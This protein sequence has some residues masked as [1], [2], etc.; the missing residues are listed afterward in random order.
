MTQFGSAELV[1]DY[2]DFG[3]PQ[4]LREALLQS[5]PGGPRLFLSPDGRYLLVWLGPPRRLLSFLHLPASPPPPQP[6][7]YLEHSWPA[8][9][10]P[11]VGLLFPQSPGQAWTMALVWE[12][13]RAEVWAPPRGP[14]DPS[15]T[16]LRSVELCQGPRARVV[17]ACCCHGDEL[18]WCEERTTANLL[19]Y[20][21]CRRSLRVSGRR[22][23]PGA[24]TIV[25]HHSPPYHVLESAGRVFMVPRATTASGCHPVLVYA[26]AEALVTLTGLAAGV[27]HSKALGEADAD[28]KKLILECAG[29]AAD[30]EI[31]H[32]AAAGPRGLL[33]ATAAGRIHLLH[34]D[35]TARHVYDL[36]ENLGASAQIKMA[37]SGDTLVCAVDSCLYLVDVRSGRLAVKQ[38]LDAGE[39]LLIDAPEGG[40]DVWLMTKV[41]VYKVGRGGVKSGMAESALLDM[42]YEEAC[43]YYQ[44]RSL[45]SAKLTAQSLKEN[46]MFQ[47]PIALAAILCRKSDVGKYAELLG[48]I[49]NELQSFLSL[50]RLKSRAAGAP[51]P[52]VARC[53]DE[54]VDLELTRLLQADPDRDGLAY[55]NSL[56]HIFPKAAWASVRNNFQFQQNGDGKLV[57]RATADLWKKVLSPLPPSAS[58]NGLLPL[59]EVICQSL[60]T[61]KPKWLPGFVQHAQEC[62]GL[63]RNFTTTTKEH[64]E[65]APPLY[66]RALSVLNKRKDNTNVELEVE[67]LLCSGRPQ[68]IIQAIHTLIRLQRWPRVMGETRRYSQLNPLIKKDIFITLLVEFVQHRQLD[69][70]VPQLCDLCPEDLTA[71]DI[72]RIVLQNIPK[73]QTVPPP[74]SADGGKHFTMGLLKPLLNKA[75]Q[76]QFRR[77]ESFPT[78]P[79]AA[80]QRTNKAAGNGED[81]SPLDIYATKAL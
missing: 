50:D 32:A 8:A 72:L 81:L 53:C 22:V 31:R 3:R 70:Y 73:M 49:D 35:G 44:R 39:V 7:D 68:A 6:G 23:T 25:L 15:W 26:P 29:A 63:Y 21:L 24:M 20:C 45:S 12:N 28:Y 58:Q 30:F 46:G 27:L 62:S 42:V 41:G 18:L 48:N 54:L 60:C 11:L 9:S 52:D 13:G 80:P 17:S 37:V 77:D 34:R 59:F 71:T 66:K 47:A 78:F 33:V 4:A 69:S 5:P 67:I 38:A 74:F 2:E 36:G 1:S 19:T 40:E 64:G 55:I 57:V 10:P 61:H 75:L 16:L 14:S 76:R 43:K 51:R 65:G 56:F 79:P